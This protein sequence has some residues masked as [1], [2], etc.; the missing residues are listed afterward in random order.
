MNAISK[1]NSNGGDADLEQDTIDLERL[2]ARVRRQV[3]HF[4]FTDAEADEVVDDILDIWTA[5][6]FEREEGNGSKPEAMLKGLITNR[7]KMIQRTQ[8]RNRA[9]EAQYCEANT[10]KDDDQAMRRDVPLGI[11]VQDAVAQLHPRW[12][13]ICEALA[14]GVPHNEIKT[15][16]GITRH[17]FDDAISGIRAHFG[18]LGLHEWL[19]E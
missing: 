9:R 6:A 17:Y 16:L 15:R 5:P 13:V 12:R 14:N 19:E 2:R 18:A 10:L 11:D 8:I 7:C 1:I 4:G 3:R